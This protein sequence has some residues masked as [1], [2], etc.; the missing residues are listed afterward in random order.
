MKA[1]SKQPQMPLQNLKL[2]DV[3]YVTAFIVANYTLFSYAENPK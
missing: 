1:A 3:P 2:R